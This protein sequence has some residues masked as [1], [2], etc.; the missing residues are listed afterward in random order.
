MWN[1]KNIGFPAHYNQRLSLAKTI[2]RI[3]STATAFDLLFA[4]SWTRRLYPAAR[5][6]RYLTKAVQSGE[7]LYGAGN[8]AQH[9]STEIDRQT[10]TSSSFSVPVGT[11]Q[12]NPLR[13][14]PHFNSHS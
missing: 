11:N 7:M 9:R 3:K 2:E 12:A 5:A 10:Q 4:Q 1:T 6:R 13:K 14:N 8:A